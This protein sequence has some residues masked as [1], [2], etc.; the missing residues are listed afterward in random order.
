VLPRLDD[1]RFGVARVLGETP[2]GTW[3]L[4][5]RDLAEPDAGTITRVRFQFHGR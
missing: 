4:R 5:A 2:N 3:T 1:W